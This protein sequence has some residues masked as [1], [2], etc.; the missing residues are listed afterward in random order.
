MLEDPETFDAEII[1]K[2]GE[3]ARKRAEKERLGLVMFTDR[4]RMENG[5]N[6]YAVAWKN[7]QTWKGIKTHMG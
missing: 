7:G 4:S 2:Y 1:H 6:G 5:A 3:E